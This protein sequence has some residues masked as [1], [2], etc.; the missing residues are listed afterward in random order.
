MSTLTVVLVLLLAAAPLPLL[1]VIRQALASDTFS[2]LGKA[3]AALWLAWVLVA[4]ALGAISPVLLYLLAAV[5][6][7]AMALFFLRGRAAYGRAAGLPPGSLALTQTLLAIVDRD[8]YL[9]AARRY[10]PVFKM[11]QFHRPTVCIIGLERGH[12]LFREHRDSFGP[13]A[14]PFNQSVAGGFLRYMDADTHGVYA[15]LFGRALAL[16]A[17]APATADIDSACRRVLRAMADACH[18]DPERDVAPRTYCEQFS[19]DAFLRVLFGLNADTPAY[20]QFNAAYEGLRHYN[21]GARVDRDTARSLQDLRD[22]L[23]DRARSLAADPESIPRCTLS[24]LHRLDADMPDRVCIDNLL[25]ILK[26]SSANVASLLLWLLKMLGEHPQWSS[27]V[28]MA[29]REGD[30]TGQLALID[31]VVKE[32]LRLA[33]SEYLYRRLREDVEFDGM[34]LPRGW[35]VRLCVRESHASNTAFTNPGE[36][37]PAR[38]LEKQSAVREYAP[39]GYG[40]HGCNGIAMNDV[41]CRSFLRTLCTE[42]DWRITRDGPLERGLRHWSHWQ[43]SSALR[44]ALRAH[45]EPVP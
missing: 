19:H 8:Y 27:T 26:I 40:A 29:G 14:Q 3:L 6:A 10:G 9:K 5:S 2:G 7:L 12:R 30:E 36:F 44:I 45:G 13:V 1:P 32:T 18:Q 41:I 23:R 35:L 11:S 16:P 42:F 24:E 4:A 25:F 39:F 17:L 20:A 37:D 31:S 34:K 33:Q 15:R 28:A 22:F 43:P 38:F 21:I